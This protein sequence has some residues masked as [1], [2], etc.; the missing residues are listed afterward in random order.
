MA[1]ATTAGARLLAAYRSLSLPEADPQF[2]N[3]RLVEYALDLTATSEVLT[4]PKSPN[5]EFFPVISTPS[6]TGSSEVE[7]V[8]RGAE[9][10]GS[11]KA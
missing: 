10:V 11:T 6:I 7:R 8:R 5:R 9:P 2:L 1:R 3:T 4:R